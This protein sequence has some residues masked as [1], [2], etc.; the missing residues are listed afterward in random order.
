MAKRVELTDLEM[1]LPDPSLYDRGTIFEW[2][3]HRDI[4]NGARLLPF[5]VAC[6]LAVPKVRWAIV[7]FRRGGWLRI[8]AVLTR[9]QSR[10]SYT[11]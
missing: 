5:I 1:Q 9:E 3:A 6:F 11:D 10:P 2:A 4:E 8:A 7:I